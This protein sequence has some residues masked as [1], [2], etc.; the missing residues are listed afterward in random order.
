MI[1][2]SKAILSG[3]TP[4][5]IRDQTQ[6][7]RVRA[8]PRPCRRSWPRDP[9]LTV[10]VITYDDG[11]QE[12]EVLHTGPPQLTE[13]TIDCLRFTRQPSGTPARTL[14]IASPA[15]LQEVVTLVRAMLLDGR[16]P[17]TPRGPHGFLATTP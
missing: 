12:L 8:A 17:L 5:Q 16:R 1:T 10:S 6:R 14:S 2:I 13:D 9:D 7:A 15:G 4:G 11:T 3:S